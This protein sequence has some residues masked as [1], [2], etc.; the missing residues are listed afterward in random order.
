MSKCIKQ[1]ELP[2]TDLSHISSYIFRTLGNTQTYIFW[3]MV[4]SSETRIWPSY[5]L[6]QIIS[7]ISEKSRWLF[8]FKQN[9]S[10][11]QQ[12]MNFWP[13]FNLGFTPC[14]AEQPLRGLQ[15]QENKAQKD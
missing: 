4:T 13:F 10:R 6:Y 7:F 8:L 2:R 11:N 12:K 3:N 15:L 14:K 1:V 9:F 5:R